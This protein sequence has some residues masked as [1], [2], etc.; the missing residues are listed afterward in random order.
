M[1]TAR[2]S[3]LPP[4]PGLTSSLALRER[5]ERWGR[6]G[7]VYEHPG[8]YSLF[9]LFLELVCWSVRFPQLSGKWFTRR[10]WTL[11]RSLSLFGWAPVR[12]QRREVAGGGRGEAWPRQHLCRG[13]RRPLGISH[14]PSARNFS[15]AREGLGASGEP[16]FC[17]GCPRPAKWRQNQAKLLSYE[18]LGSFSH[19][20]P[21]AGPGP[22]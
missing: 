12:I 5:R 21:V 2:R 13:F 17:A 7:W 19:S 6:H 18:A 20:A 3:R 10:R 16:Q 9:A 15:G 4:P 14:T 11:A 1:A 8:I 22:L